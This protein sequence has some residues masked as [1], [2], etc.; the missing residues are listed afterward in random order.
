MV[1]TGQTQSKHRYDFLTEESRRAKLELVPGAEVVPQIYGTETHFH[2]ALSTDSRFVRLGFREYTLVSLLDG[3]TTLAHALAESSQVLG[4]EALTE[5]EVDQLIDW[6]LDQGVLR[7]KDSRSAAVARKAPSNSTQPSM[8]NRLNPFWLK[9]PFSGPLKNPDRVLDALMP[10]V[11]W[12]FH[13]AAVLAM[14]LLI[15][16]GALAAASYRTE[17]WQSSTGILVPENWIPLLLTWVGLKIVHEL[18]HALTCRYHGGSVR[19]T[20]IIFILLAPMAFVDVT[21]SWKF[22]SRWRRMSVAAAGMFVELTIASVAVLLW[23]QVDSIGAKQLLVNVM[24]AASISTVLFNANPLM[25]F[26]GYYLLSDLLKIPNLYSNGT[27][28]VK[29]LLQWVM[30]GQ[31]KIGACVELR[32]FPWTVRLYGILASIW[33]VLICV[34]LTLTASVLLGGWG[35]L[36]AGLGLLNWVGKPLWSAGQDF[37][38]RYQRSPHQAW[39]AAIVAST[40]LGLMAI[41]WFW[42]PNPFPG[43]VPCV[44]DYAQAAQ[45]R[46]NADGF[47]QQVL[48]EPGQA[49]IAGTPLLQLQNRE[50]E[51]R[52]AELNA[53]LEAHRTRER[54]AI[55]QQD[56]AA[57]QIA[58]RDQQAT[59]SMLAELRRE[60]D[61]LTIRAP[62]NGLVV[63]NNLGQRQGTFVKSGDIL[64]VI[65]N[66][67]YKEVILS[68]AAEDAS[69]INGWQEQSVQ[70]H[71]GSRRRFLASVKRVNPKAVDSLPHPSLSVINGGPLALRE[72]S[73]DQGQPRLAGPRFTA[74]GKLN[75]PI[76]A[77]LLAGETG[78]GI[79]YRSDQSLGQ[80]IWESGRRWLERQV[81]ATQDAAP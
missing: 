28:S 1:T 58:A 24:L 68:I 12:C 10:A 72:Q 42:L 45:V 50:L 16:V 31:R 75:A 22:A 65:G 14:S 56:A 8:L 70:I 33:K 59:S 52:I 44:V 81:A 55:D 37:R 20:G 49:V 77:Q 66:D 9:V 63:A 38:Q 18:A 25:R 76:A 80:W 4:K 7:F 78:V 34:G 2:I 13:P 17:I 23:F 43:Y 48:V 6:L 40:T 47:V 15:L 51:A 3:H 67:N 61:E 69:A 60:Q 36:L 5:S 62:I 39:R 26:D 46:A 29:Q 35:V 11:G 19:E 54:V 64:L 57:A 32:Q 74:R 27:E 71:L 30:Y 53:E 79:L 41:S 21:S 73:D